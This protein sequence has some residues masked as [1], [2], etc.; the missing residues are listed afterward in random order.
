LIVSREN[1]RR[2]LFTLES[3]LGWSRLKRWFLCLL[4]RL[5][6]AVQ[7]LERIGSRKQACA[8]SELLLAIASNFDLRNVLP[9][10]WHR[11]FGGRNGLGWLKSRVSFSESLGFIPHLFCFGRLRWTN[12]TLFLHLLWCGSLLGN[13]DFGLLFGR[14][15]LFFDLWINWRRCFLDFRLLAW[16]N[17]LLYVISH[18]LKVF[19]DSLF[20]LF[21][22]TLRKDAGQSW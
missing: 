10:T 8:S 6:L 21:M 5:K 9:S 22:T 19:I 4:N 14:R 12:R 13:F 15:S 20:I 18:R 16:G 7:A 17:K 3:W 11:Q 2:I 1:G